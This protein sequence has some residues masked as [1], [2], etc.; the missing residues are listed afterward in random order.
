MWSEFDYY[1]DPRYEDDFEAYGQ[2]VI[3]ARG[4]D[5]TWADYAEQLASKTPTPT[6]MWDLYEHAD[7]ALKDVLRD[8]Q[9]SL[10]S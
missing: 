10:Q 7:A 1:Y 8:A 4:S 9:N 3:A 5:V 6:A 2:Q